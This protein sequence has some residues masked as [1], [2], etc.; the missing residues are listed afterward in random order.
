MRRSYAE[1]QEA[2]RGAVSDSIAGDPLFSDPE[3]GDF[4]LRPGS[5]VA[6][7]GSDGDDPGIRGIP[8]GP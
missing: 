5:P 4:R 2:S 3:R 8:R 6:G 1:L 7:A